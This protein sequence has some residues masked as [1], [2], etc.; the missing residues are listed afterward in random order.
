MVKIR[1]TGRGGPRKGAGRRPGPQED[2]RSKPVTVMLT[3]AE[4]RK[5]RRLARA[6]ELPHGTLAYEFVAAAL[7]RRN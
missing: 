6:R 3:Q 4:F 5:L 2:V 7:E 1:R